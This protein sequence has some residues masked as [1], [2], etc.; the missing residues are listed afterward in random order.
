M[1]LPRVYIN[2]F[3]Y[4]AISGSIGSMF[5]STATTAPDIYGFIAVHQFVVKKETA[6]AT[7]SCLVFV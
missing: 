6:A 7:L 2:L 3:L 4:E 5:I 1:L